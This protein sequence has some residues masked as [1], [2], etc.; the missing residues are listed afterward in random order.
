M[1]GTKVIRPLFISHTNAVDAKAARPPGARDRALEAMGAVDGPRSAE[2]KARV[3]MNAY[4][5]GQRQHMREV[6]KAMNG[7]L[8]V[9]REALPHVRL[10]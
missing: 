6:A 2:G 7:F 9:S 10:P 8:E 4:R 5:G 1:Y 3:S